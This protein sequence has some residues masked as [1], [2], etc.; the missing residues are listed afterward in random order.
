[1]YPMRSMNP[2]EGQAPR[3]GVPRSAHVLLLL[4]GLI[5]VAL[6]AADALI[7]A[8]LHHHGSLIDQLIRPDSSILLIRLVI[9]GLILALGT[10][11]YVFLRRERFSADQAHVAESFLSSVVDNIPD[12]V[13]IKDARELRFVRV[14]PAGER[15]LGLSEREL[16]GKSDYD[17]FPKAQAD[18]FTEKDRDVLESGT[19]LDI[20]EEQI[21]TRHIGRRILHTKKVPILGKDG[22]PAFMLGVSEDITERRQAELAAQVEKARAEHYLEISR[23]MIVGLDR[24]GRINLINPRGCEIL[25]CTEAEILG[26]SWFDTVLPEKSR[27]RELEVVQDLLDG[28]AEPEGVHESEVLTKDG[29]VRHM[30]WNVALQ[31]GPQGDVVGTLCSGQDVT[32]RVTAELDGQR[33]H[34]E[35]AHVMRLSTMGE[36]ASGMAHELNQ[37]LTAVMTYCATALAM[38]EQPTPPPERITGILTKAMEQ[39]S[40]AGELIRRLRDFVSK[41]SNTRELIDLDRLIPEVMGFLEWELRDSRVEWDLRLNGGDRPVFADRVQIEQV[42]IN[43]VRN[44]LDSISAG[45]VSGG[46]VNVETC[47]TEP[48]MLRTTVWDNGPGIDPSILKRLFQPFQTTK[49]KG[50]GI[51]LSISRSIIEAH[52]GRLWGE[53]QPAGG[54]VF[55]FDLPLAAEDQ[56][57]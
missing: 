39:A 57:G 43:L 47:V 1:M 7:Q 18:F 20:P 10:L 55:G 24:E 26:R 56:D 4:A 11:A 28:H 17:F 19:V 41:G 25:G 34:Q 51:G 14:N 49:E 6:Y 30:S 9:A 23:S 32:D 8:L 52:G 13:F 44:S 53:N 38:L 40:R 36:M 31:R 27:K 3:S 5:A 50:M 45:E 15:L 42:L 16:L 2:Q 35:L 46:R 48:A 29:Q 21:D 33:H 37:P 12:M 54:S 22:R